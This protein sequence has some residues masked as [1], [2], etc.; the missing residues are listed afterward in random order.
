MNAEEREQ[1][2]R[3]IALRAGTASE[4]AKWYGVTLPW[5]KRFVERNAEELEAIRAESAEP[6]TYSQ[7]E[8]TPTELDQLWITNKF[9]RLLRLQEVADLTYGAIQAGGFSD[10]VLVREFR[11]YLTLAA[12][13]L[14]QLLHRGSGDTGS[15][16]M[17]S[18]DMQVVDMEKLR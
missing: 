13:E 10:A 3:D 11:S 1:L 7:E 18:V 2:K 15:D 5:L 6:Q 14:G 4:I 8:P 12:N 16:E 9:H 17:L